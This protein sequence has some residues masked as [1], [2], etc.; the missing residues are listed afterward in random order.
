MARIN[1]TIASLVLSPSRP[2]RA[3]GS[4]SCFSRRRR[5]LCSGG[6]SLRRTVCQRSSTNTKRFCSNRPAP[7]VTPLSLGCSPWSAWAVDSGM[8]TLRYS[9]FNDH[10]KER[11]AVGC[12]SSC[13]FIS[14]MA[15]WSNW[16]MSTPFECA[17]AQR[18]AWFPSLRTA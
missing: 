6:H 1:S 8:K 2:S 3:T 11:S 16:G 12:S 9:G 18:I 14:S 7:T 10:P 4:L 15:F 13:S 5:A 17:A